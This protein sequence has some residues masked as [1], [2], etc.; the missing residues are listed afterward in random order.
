METNWWSDMMKLKLKLKQQIHLKKYLSSF[1]TYHQELSP[2]QWMQFQE[3]F[4]LYSAVKKWWYKQ[5]I[6]GP[7]KRGNAAIFNSK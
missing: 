2:P 3:Y 6:I 4:S 5:S 1:S 7:H